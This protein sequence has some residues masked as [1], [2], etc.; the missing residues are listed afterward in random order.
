MKLVDMKRDATDR[1]A[2][3]V[4]S[5]MPAYPSGLRLVLDDEALERLGLEDVAVGDVLDVAARAKVVSYTE[6][7]GDDDAVTCRLELQITALGVDGDAGAARARRD[8]DR[9]N[10]LGGFA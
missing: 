6:N 2:G 9:L 7:A 8:D 5:E 10:E 4:A 3:D 1:D